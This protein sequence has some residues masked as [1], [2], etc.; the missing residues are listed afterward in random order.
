M[1]IMKTLKISVNDSSYIEINK[2]EEERDK[3]I[4]VINASKKNEKTF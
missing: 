3:L 1:K 4:Y 2:Y